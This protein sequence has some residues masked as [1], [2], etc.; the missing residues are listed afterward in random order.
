[1]S[2][3]CERQPGLVE[4]AGLV[5]MP[6]DDAGSALDTRSLNVL[7]HGRSMDAETRRKL[8]DGLPRAVEHDQLVDLIISEAN[9]H[10]TASDLA[11]FGSANASTYLDVRKLLKQNS[12][13]RIGSDKVHTKLLDT[14]PSERG[15]K[16]IAHGRFESGIETVYAAR[17]HLIEP[18]VRL[19]YAFDTYV[20]GDHFSVSLAGV[21]FEDASSEPR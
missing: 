16:E 17:F 8:V 4:L 11:S 21:E 13:V 19:I 6:I 15:G 18:N 20:A 1:M 5:E 3:L 9:L 2:H 14:Q 7:H 12:G 10:L